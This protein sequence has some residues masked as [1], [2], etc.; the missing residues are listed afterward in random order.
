MSRTDRTLIYGV[1]NW[2]KKG[3]SSLPPDGFSQPSSQVSKAKCFFPSWQITPIAT[4]GSLE[5][6]C[7]LYLSMLQYCCLLTPS[8]PEGLG[9]C[10]KREGNP[11]CSLRRF[12]PDLS[13]AAK[14]NPRGSVCLH[15][16]DLPF[17]PECAAL[18]KPM[19]YMKINKRYSVRS[20]RSSKLDLEPR[21]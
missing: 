12:W 20:Q 15:C 17:Q 9:N 11:S 2:D 18:I 3:W 6:V 7:F 1:T 16:S 19:V 21:S 5:K 10:Y 14:S 13:A 8:H 4:S